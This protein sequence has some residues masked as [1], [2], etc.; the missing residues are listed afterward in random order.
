MHLEVFTHF[1]YTAVKMF[2]NIP[3]GKGDDDGSII[4]T[5]IRE[6]RL[7]TEQRQVRWETLQEI[8]EKFKV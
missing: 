7:P 4:D 6:S 2:G 1:Q 3:L 5:L 8:L